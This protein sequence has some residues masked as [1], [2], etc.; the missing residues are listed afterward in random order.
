MVGDGW[1]GTRMARFLVPPRTP[2]RDAPFP[3][4]G[5]LGSWPGLH[6][7]FGVAVGPGGFTP[8]GQVACSGGWHTRLPS[9]RAPCGHLRAAAGG[10]NPRS[11]FA[12]SA[13]LS[14]GGG[15]DPG[16]DLVGPAGSGVRP[17]SEAFPLL[18]AGQ[19]EADGYA[20]LGHGLVGV[21]GLGGV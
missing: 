12:G 18:F 14:C 3:V 9:V 19:P 7:R 13:S 17:C 16:C 6:R 5:V 8:R 10:V 2:A 1:G 20:L 21:V 4:P 11:L 15:V